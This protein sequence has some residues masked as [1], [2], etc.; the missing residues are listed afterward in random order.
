[1]KHCPVNAIAGKPKYIHVI[2]QE[3]CI[4]CGTC[5]DV[6]PFDAIVKLSGETIETP[7]KPIPIKK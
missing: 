3:T 2:N 4:S 7:E 5:Y 6:C 1:M